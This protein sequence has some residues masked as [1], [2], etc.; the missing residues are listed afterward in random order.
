MKRCAWLLAFILVSIVGT[1]AQVITTVAGNGIAGSG[2]DGSAAT[3]AQLNQPYGVAADDSGN[4]YIADF[5]NAVIRK[6]NTT[7]IISTFAGGGAAIT[8]EVS[9]T[10]S[11]ISSPSGVAIDKHGNVYI[12]GGNRVRMVDA[13]GIIHTVAGGGAT[14]AVDSIAAIDAAITAYGVAIDKHG[15]LYITDPS[16][17]LMYKVDTFGIIT[18]IAG[19]GTTIYANGVSATATGLFTPWGVAID[20]KGNVYES[21]YPTD[22]IHKIDTAGIIT[23]FAGNGAVG[24]SGDHAAATAAK[25]FYPY[26]VATDKFNNVYI[27]D[28]SNERVRMVDT[29]GIIYTIAGTGTAGSSGDGGSPTS[30]KLFYPYG[31]ATNNIGSIYIADYNNNKIRAIINHIPSFIDNTTRYLTMCENA[32]ATSIDTMLTAMDI[33]V[34]QAMKW[35]VADAAIHGTVAGSGYSLSATGGALTPSGFTY[36]PLTGYSG[37][38]TFSIAVTDGYIADTL[39]FSVTVLPATTGGA[40]TGIDS[41]C[42]GDT[43]R[44]ADTTAGGVWSSLNETRATISADGL[45]TGMTP[46]TDI[47]IYTVTNICGM[48]NAYFPI[49]IRP[50]SECNTGVATTNT[51][52]QSFTIYPNPT[53][54]NITLSTS[55]GIT[56]PMQITITNIV[57]EKILQQITSTNTEFYLSL[58]Q[59]VGIYFLSASAAHSRYA[60]KVIIE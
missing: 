57:G 21:E 11:A 12:A 53:T 7:G 48:A 60:V 26:G 45:V 43:I 40:I 24:Y 54:G 56:E 14:S 52:Q 35:T 36:T 18:T 30:A 39:S 1:H 44:V 20:G 49:T 55:S 41:V 58:K 3:A 25:L 38:D 6:V 15:N 22:V 59:P 29:L 51:Q 10:T 13:A 33:D 2:G 23:I 19:N 50:L 42:P 17:N 34:N 9:A 16:A 4:V 47:I 32:A 27:A 37:Q 5:A 46:G 8:D 31:V 28:R